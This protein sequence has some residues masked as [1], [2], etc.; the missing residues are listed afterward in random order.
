MLLHGF[1]GAATAGPRPASDPPSSRHPR[2]APRLP[3]SRVPRRKRGAGPAGRFPT[4]HRR[5]KGQAGPTG[6]P[7]GLSPSR[8]LAIQS[9]DRVE[10]AVLGGIVAILAGV[11]QSLFLTPR[12]QCQVYSLSSTSATSDPRRLRYRARV[13]ASR[14]PAACSSCSDVKAKKSIFQVITDEARQSLMRTISENPAIGAHEITDAFLTDPV[15][16]WTMPWCMKH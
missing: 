14:I 12:E 16:A 10:S 13:Q 1:A 2:P 3:L 9:T 8:R 15:Q 4:S 11:T 7:T 6:P 5:R